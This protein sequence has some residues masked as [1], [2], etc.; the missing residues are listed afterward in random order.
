[1]KHTL[2]FADPGNISVLRTPPS[3]EISKVESDRRRPWHCWA[4]WVQGELSSATPTHTQP[5]QSHSHPNANTHN[6]INKCFIRFL[7]WP[8]GWWSSSHPGQRLGW[9]ER[10]ECLA[11]SEKDSIVL[12]SPVEI[13]EFNHLS[14]LSFE[15]VLGTFFCLESTEAGHVPIH[16]ALKLQIPLFLW[17]CPNIAS[18]QVQL[19]LGWLILSWYSLRLHATT[20]FIFSQ[21]IQVS[22]LVLCDYFC[23]DWES[24]ILQLEN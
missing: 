12:F 8:L 21:K 13:V 16:L 9:V 24:F 5:T 19:V 6:L 15:L 11:G 23:Y 7:F 14:F 2:R 1:M 10:C 20:Y 17:A 3:A 18:F 22:V 4:L